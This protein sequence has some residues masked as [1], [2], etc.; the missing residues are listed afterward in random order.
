MNKTKCLIISGCSGAGKSTVIN[1][2]SKRHWNVV[3]EAGRQI[4]QSELATNGTALPWK[5]T[6]SFV[7]KASELSLTQISTA[8]RLNAKGPVISDRSI[9]DLISYLNFCE[10][11]IPDDLALYL[12]ENKYSS[13]I[14]WAPPWEE[15]FTSDSERQK[16]FDEALN[17]Y[18]HL[19][20][21][22]ESLGYSLIEI[23]RL[24]VARRVDFIED[25]LLSSKPSASA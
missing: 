16:T 17:E 8:L 1:A 4:V 7:R 23:P 25:T 14:I 9:V 6:L 24:S 3:S 2:L 12:T 19:K 11:G 22:Y 10:I 20:I 21:S 18:E 5:D 15:L 13:T